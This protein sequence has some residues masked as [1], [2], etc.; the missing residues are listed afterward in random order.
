MSIL[1]V[2]D[3]VVFDNSI[4]NAEKHSHLPYGSNSYK[5]NDEIRIRIEHQDVYTLPSESYIYLEGKLKKKD[6]T[7]S[8][9]AKFANN[10]FAFLFEE[11]RYEIG[12]KVIDRTRNVGITT[13]MKNYV[14][15]TPNTSTQLYN[16]GWKIDTFP[17]SDEA[18][19]SFNV[20]VPLKYLLG[21]AEDFNRILLNVRQELV[22]IRSN[23]DLNAVYSTDPE[24]EIKVE[25]E[26]I[27]WKVPHI[28]VDDAERLN[29]INFV[30]SGAE[31]DIP[32]RSW[33]LHEFPL[34]QKT[35]QHTWTVK[36][37]SQLEKP[38]YI[39]FGFQTDKKNSVHKNCTT[40]NHC[41]LTNFKLFLNSEIYPYENLNLN[42]KKSQYSTLYEMYANFQKSY[43]EKEAAPLLDPTEFKDNA[44]L[45]VIDCSRQN[46]ILNVGSV[47]IR[48]EF[49]TNENIPDKTSAFCLILHDR[50]IKY[51]PLTG[52]IRSL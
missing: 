1:D 32:F 23:S 31:L 9:T 36:S 30:S 5:N 18:T 35:Q 39:I 27:V 42:F 14:S 47:D 8:K 3:K 51:V 7:V 37:T 46:E 38:R 13:T 49:E 43:Y 26:K 19:G 22:L 2:S 41:N 45:V 25:I 44:P 10:G 34:L 17:V 29:L 6:G 15:L 24:E 52:T 12:G 20:C 40:F 16:A 11:I 21:F 4:V 33:E 50:I 28:N 48:L